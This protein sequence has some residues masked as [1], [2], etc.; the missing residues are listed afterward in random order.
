MRL[1]TRA[2]PIQ[3][4]AM[5]WALRLLMVAVV[6]FGLGGGPHGGHLPYRSVRGSDEGARDLQS[7]LISAARRAAAEAV[8][9]LPEE[10]GAAEPS[11]LAGPRLDRRATGTSD[12]SAAA[13]NPGVLAD[14]RTAIRLTYRGVRVPHSSDEPPERPRS[15]S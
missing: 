1:G 14:Q 3:A 4:C 9:R 10:A 12:P 11:D 5:R 8:V 7:A 15:P 13:R 6:G 2:V